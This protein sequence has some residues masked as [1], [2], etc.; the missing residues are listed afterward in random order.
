M[1]KKEEIP[2]RVVPVRKA[3]LKKLCGEEALLQEANALTKIH[4]NT[5]NKSII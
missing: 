1:L 3:S 5:Q 2:Q 4:T